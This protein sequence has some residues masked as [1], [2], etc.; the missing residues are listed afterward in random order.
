MSNE[1]NQSA[2]DV[3]SGA[4]LAICV[5]CKYWRRGGRFEHVWS[6][7][8]KPGGERFTVGPI[9]RAFDEVVDLHTDPNE[10]FGICLH[11]LISCC[12]RNGW[13]GWENSNDPKA[14][15][16]EAYDE[17]GFISTGE[18]FGCRHFSANSNDEP[19]RPL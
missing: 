1:K 8:A 12:G 15:K 5:N 3:G 4:L 11:P 14:L 19:R 16:V 13:L 17:R 10:K 7:N 6:A 2:Q 18:E 9:T